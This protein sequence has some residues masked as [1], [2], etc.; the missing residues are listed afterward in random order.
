MVAKKMTSDK[1]CSSCKDSHN[2]SAVY[3][4][5]GNAKGPSVAMKV[6]VAF[7]LPIII[8]IITLAVSENWLK[9]VFDNKN[10]PSAIGAVIAL[11]AVVV[12][13]FAVRLLRNRKSKASCPKVLKET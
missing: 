13:I 4:Q 3:G 10:M 2:C 9:S 11:I 7:L 1:N 5:I 12:Y 8:F 6:V